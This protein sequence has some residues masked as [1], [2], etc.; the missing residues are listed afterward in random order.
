MGIARALGTSGLVA[1]AV[2]IG[3]CARGAPNPD[4]S[5]ERV[6]AKIARQGPIV[7]GMPLRGDHSTVFTIEVRAPRPVNI[8]MAYEGYTLDVATPAG[9]GCEGSV[10]DATI[11]AGETVTFDLGPEA[12]GHR[13]WKIGRYDATL[14]VFGY[15]PDECD[16]SPLA[17]FSVI[18]DRD[19]ARLVGVRPA[20]PPER[21][22]GD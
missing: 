16:T 22:S 3:G 20:R 17:W 15:C 18:V 19:G 9:T 13:R 11:K 6:A 1:V 7:R 21:G 4:A 14:G 5:S 12:C 10:N 8:H 2:L